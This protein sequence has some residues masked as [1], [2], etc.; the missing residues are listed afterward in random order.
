MNLSAEKKTGSCHSEVVKGPVFVDGLYCPRG[1]LVISQHR[2][3]AT[4]SNLCGSC[5][6]TCAA[7]HPKLPIALGD[8]WV[9]R[10]APIAGAFRVAE[11]SKSYEF[12]KFYHFFTIF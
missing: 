2:R 7:T 8:G 10:R 6:A 11:A 12:N 1:I 4:S 5:I 3:S 9:R